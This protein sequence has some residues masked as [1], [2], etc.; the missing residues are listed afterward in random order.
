MLLGVMAVL[1]GP[2]RPDL[3]TLIAILMLAMTAFSVS[4]VV[5]R[6]VPFIALGIGATAA[7]GTLLVSLDQ[8]A[9]RWSPAD[10]GQ[11]VIADVQIDSLVR[12]TTTGIEFDAEL[13]IES[14]ASL[15]RTLRA[16][17]ESP[18]SSE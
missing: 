8:L 15:H 17:R 18:R 16:R 6:R 14:P 10:Q 11:R 1:F 3:Y 7:L 2:L 9:Q 5:R 13:M 12:R 4:F